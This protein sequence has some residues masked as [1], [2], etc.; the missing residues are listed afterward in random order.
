[1]SNGISERDES[2]SIIGQHYFAPTGCERATRIEIQNGNTQL[3]ISAGPWGIATTEDR[4]ILV[5]IFA[6]LRGRMRVSAKTSRT[7]SFEAAD[8]FRAMGTQNDANAQSNLEASLVRLQSTTLSIHF[9]NG[10]FGLDACFGWID[11][12]ELKAKTDGQGREILGK[13]TVN[14]NEW[15][16]D[17]LRPGHPSLLEGS[18][19]LPPSLISSIRYGADV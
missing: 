12:L 4:E 19:Q 8:L 9:S 18:A 17:L 3:E 6:L 1:M 14:L 10:D 2:D 15:I 13:I 7:V 11:S 5:Y 16:F